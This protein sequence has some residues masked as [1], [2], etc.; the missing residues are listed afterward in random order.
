MQLL[1]HPLMRH[2]IGCVRKFNRVM[3][4]LGERLADDW[5]DPI[6]G[7]NSSSIVASDDD[8]NAEHNVHRVRRYG[9][10]EHVNEVHQHSEE[11]GRGGQYTKDES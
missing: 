6:V 8:E 10:C 5:N 1:N 9:A 3:E 2:P 11:C 4:P 7:T